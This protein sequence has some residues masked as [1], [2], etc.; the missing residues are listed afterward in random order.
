MFRYVPAAAAEWH[1]QNLAAEQLLPGADGM[2]HQGRRYGPSGQAV[3][4]IRAG[5]TVHQGRRYGPSGQ[6]VWSVKAGGMAHQGRQYGPSY[7]VQI[8]T[9]R[10]L[11]FS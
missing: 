2:V 8:T 4:S 9:D 1:D 5:G 7:T 11:T 6:A 10:P 3:R